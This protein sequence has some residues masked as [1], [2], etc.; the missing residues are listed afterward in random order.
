[1]WMQAWQEDQS[2]RQAE[3]IGQ[4][5][6]QTEEEVTYP[7]TAAWMCLPTWVSLRPSALHSSATLAGVIDCAPREGPGDRNLW[8][9][10]SYGDSGLPVD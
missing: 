4:E 8:T 3:S 1:M 10:K 9:A 7:D 5:Q 2:P 6:S